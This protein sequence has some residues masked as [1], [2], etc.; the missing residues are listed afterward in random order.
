[1]IK[2]HIGKLIPDLTIQG[3]PAPYPVLNERAIR[4]TAWLLFAVW[5]SIMRYTI[6][7][8]DRA[9]M[10]G[11]VPVFWL[12]FVIVTARWP[13]YSPLAWIGNI[14]VSRQRPEYIWAIQKRFARWIGAIMAS[15]MMILVWIVPQPGIWPFVVCMTCLIFMRLESAV[16]LCVGCK[17]YYALIHRWI[18]QEPD[19]RP[20]CPGWVCEFKYQGKDH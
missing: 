10:L 9:M 7:T 6:L 12:H 17:L 5:L 16:G 19:H 18:I 2:K 13:H 8:G 11:V 15:V 1:M 4:A 20:A 3:K 14:L